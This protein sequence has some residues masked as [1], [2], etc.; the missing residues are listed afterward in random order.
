MKLGR[1]V[2]TKR[3]ISFIATIECFAGHTSVLMGFFKAPYTG[4]YKVGVKYSGTVSVHGGLDPK[5]PT[6]ANAT[7]IKHCANQGREAIYE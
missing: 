5:Q 4:E 6:L 3:P 1:I 7:K 2:V